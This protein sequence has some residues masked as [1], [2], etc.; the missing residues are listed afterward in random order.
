MGE[1]VANPRSGTRRLSYDRTRTQQ[2]GTS[3]EG[4]DF[5]PQLG[6]CAVLCGGVCDARG[7]GVG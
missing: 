1:H 3:R 7:D 2:G 4:A 5:C 6:P